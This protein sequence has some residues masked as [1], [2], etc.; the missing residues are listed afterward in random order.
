MAANN[1]Q[2]PVNPK[3]GDKNRSGFLPPRMSFL[4]IIAI[5]IL[6]FL[7]ITG[8]YS[9]LSNRSDTTTQ[10]PLSTLAADVQTGKVSSLSLEGDQVTAQYADKSVKISQKETDSSL[11]ESLLRLGVSP[12][13]MATTTIDVLQ[14]S[15]FWFWV[16]QTA[17]FLAP[18]L[19]L[20][21]FVW[22]LSRQVRGAGIQALT[23]GQ[24]K[25]RITLPTDTKQKV[26]FKDVAG[27]KE[28]KQELLEIVDFLRNPKKFI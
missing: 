7:V 12:A 18:V 15:G 9:E 6:I 26:T 2:N 1:P 28:A 3:N 10:V 11:T 8:V 13:R 14:P 16:G 21:F 20:V 27:A 19:L 5:V 17:P 23:F 24:S 4:N 25:A 22:F